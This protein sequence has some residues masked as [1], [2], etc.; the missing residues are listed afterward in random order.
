MR[1]TGGRHSSVA[2]DTASISAEF[3]FQTATYNH[4]CAVRMMICPGLSL[5]RFEALGLHIYIDYSY[6]SKHPDSA[7]LTHTSNFL[8]S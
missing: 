8:N 3:S 6:V 7:L 2:P 1:I 5:R 4:P